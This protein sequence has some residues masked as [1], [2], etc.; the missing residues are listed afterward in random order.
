MFVSPPLS[1]LPF[2]LLAPQREHKSNPL[3]KLETIIKATGVVPTVNQIERHPMLPQ[4]E[5]IAYC[6]EK[7]IHITAYSVCFSPSPFHLTPKQKRREEEK[8]E[9]E[10]ENGN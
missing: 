6:K 8:E 1:P 9:L 10:G 2:S 5:L 4:P 3:V 7:G